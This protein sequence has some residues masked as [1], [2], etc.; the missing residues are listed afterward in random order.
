MRKECTVIAAAIILLM[1]I[2]SVSVFPGNFDD[3]YRGGIIADDGAPPVISLLS[4]SN[5]SIVKPFSLLDLDVT[6]NVAVSHVLYNWDWIDNVTLDSPY[7]LFART[8]EVGHYLYVYANDTSDTWTKAVFYFISDGTK[9]D[10]SLTTPTNNSVQLSGTD[11][12]A[13]ITD[14]HLTDVFYSWD[15]LEIL[16]IWTEPYSTQLIGG[17]G[18]HT[19]HVYANDSAGNWI[20]SNFT[21]ITDD[22]AP[23]INLRDLTNGTARQSNSVVDIDIV[24]ASTMTVLYNWNNNLDNTTWVEPYQTIVPNGEILHTLRVFANDSFGRWQQSVFQFIGDNTPPELLLTSP[25]NNSLQ[26]SGTEVAISVTDTH[27][28]SVIY[29]WDDDINQM[30]SGTTLIPLGDGIH[31]LN[32]FANDSAENIMIVSCVFDVDDSPPVVIG[33]EDFESTFH[34]ELEINWVVVD[35]H[36]ENYV[37]LVNESEAE[38]GTWQS[39][40]LSFDIPGEFYQTHWPYVLNCTI[41]FSDSLGNTA[42]DTVFLTIV[43]PPP[44][45]DYT[46]PDYTIPDDSLDSLVIGIV[47]GS[48]IGFG[49]IIIIFAI[50]KHKRMALML[51]R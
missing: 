34:G 50:R 48:I 35:A 46:V 9:P 7:D 13:T 32:I 36:P 15:T 44:P 49:T 28:E 4:P 10:V 29:N 33:P 41:I 23:V 14:L 12:N 40:G 24:D 45:I 16:N 26:F 8:S 27:L 17:D 38:S 37:V 39:G 43:S 6:D 19:L 11:I 51:S 42:T 22:D 18:S 20:G 25:T 30:W 47:I 1:T 2:P 5:G 21:F 3:T 31:S